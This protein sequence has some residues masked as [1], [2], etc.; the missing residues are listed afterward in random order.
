MLAH[1]PPFPL[2]INHDVENHHDFSTEDE[3]AIALALRRRNRVRRVHLRLP[4]LSL[5]KL[6]TSLDGEFPILEFLRIRPLT[7]NGTRLTLP[8]TFEAPHL[9]HLQLDHF[10]SP[11][12]SSLLRIATCLVTVSLRWIHPSIY[13]H[14]N[15]ILQPFSLLRQLETLEIGFCF[16]VPKRDIER[17]LLNTPTMTRPM[18]SNLQ[19]FVFWG[20]SAYLE[21]LLPRMTTP[22]LERLCV[23]FFNQ[24]QFVVPRLLQFMTTTENLR[25]S[26][27]KL[28]FYHEA[29]V[30]FVYSRVES[31]LATLYVDVTCGHLDW[32]VS[33]VAQ[34]FNTLNPLFSEVADLTLGYREHTLSSE[35]HNQADRTRWR[36][37]LGSFRNVK[38]LRVHKGLVGELSRSLRL[39]GEPPLD[40]LPE[41]R[42]IICPAG[43]IDDKTFTPFTHEREVIGRPVNLIIEDVPVGLGT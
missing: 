36:E 4:V 31:R 30:V 39:D 43:S 28:V 41:L 15:D 8:S 3:D 27:A 37:L 42:D 40:I 32:Q 14:P 10:A 35:W 24:L 33:S 21:A 13:P 1:S 38:T 18:L 16:P 22:L 7:K 26:S 6:I 5:Q 12:G 23:H 9:R 19:S 11:R 25:F 17:Q 34:I 29:V 20:V 2:V